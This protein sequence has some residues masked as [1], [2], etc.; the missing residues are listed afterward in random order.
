MKSYDD[1]DD[2]TTSYDDVCWSVEAGDT[3]SAGEEGGRSWDEVAVKD[4][5][6]SKQHSAE[7][8]R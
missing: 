2:N 6:F 8:V 4:Q 3:V 7:V 1:D 5:I